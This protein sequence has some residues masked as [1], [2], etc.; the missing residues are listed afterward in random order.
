M[1][2]ATRNYFRFLWRCGRLAF[3][4]DWRYYTWIGVLT[5]FCLLGLKLASCYFD[6]SAYF[7]TRGAR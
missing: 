2:T 1:I 3:V 4:G 7:F 6:F 5:V